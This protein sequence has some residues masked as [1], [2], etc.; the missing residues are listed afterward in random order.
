MTHIAGIKR[1]SPE[2]YDSVTVITGIIATF[3]ET[4]LP[5][6]AI[7]TSTPGVDLV[8]PVSFE[9]VGGE[10]AIVYF[11]ATIANA[12]PAAG[13]ANVRVVIDGVDIQYNITTQVGAGAPVPPITFGTSNP[14]GVT[15]ETTPFA[16]GLHTIAVK[17]QCIGGMTSAE[18]SDASVV[19]MIANT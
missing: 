18:V 15:Y 13:Q 1:R 19:V 14:I 12:L 8:P 4:S 16:A 5:P 3:G 2:T 7:D 17:G 6:S 11:S 9:A 10:R